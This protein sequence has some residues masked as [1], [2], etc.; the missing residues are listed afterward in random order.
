MSAKQKTHPLFQRAPASAEQKKFSLSPLSS[1]SLS[2]LIAVDLTEKLGF[3]KGF[4]F[5]FFG[6]FIV[7]GERERERVSR[8]EIS[9]GFTLKTTGIRSSLYGELKINKLSRL[10]LHIDKVF[11]YLKKVYTFL[12]VL[13][14]AVKRLTCH[15]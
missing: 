1:G 10:N 12:N 9:I 15:L 8:V 11:L 6:F 4:F 14:Q 13:A 7:K 2:M 5:I 3:M